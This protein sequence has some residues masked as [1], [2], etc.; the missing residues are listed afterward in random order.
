MVVGGTE[1]LGEEV[2]E[3]QGRWEMGPWSYYL[4]IALFF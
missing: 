4:G 1:C 3:E 2:G